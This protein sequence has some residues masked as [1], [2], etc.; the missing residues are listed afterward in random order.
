MKY[1]KVKNTAKGNICKYIN[2]G[3]IINSNKL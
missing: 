1:F 2:M 3:K